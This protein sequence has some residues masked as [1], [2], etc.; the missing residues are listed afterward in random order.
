MENTLSAAF[1]DGW[2]RRARLHASEEWKI[3]FLLL[4]RM[5]GLGGLVYMPLPNE[6]ISTHFFSTNS[7]YQTRLTRLLQR[8]YT[9]EVQP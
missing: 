2:T 5:V 4:L 3:P 8:L 6:A 1:E 7:W 9:L